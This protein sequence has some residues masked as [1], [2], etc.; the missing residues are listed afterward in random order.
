[1]FF[2]QRNGKPVA[3]QFEVVPIS[4]DF[5]MNIWCGVLQFALISLDQKLPQTFL[6]PEPQF[7]LIAPANGNNISDA[8]CIHD[9]AEADFH[10]FISIFV[11]YRLG[12]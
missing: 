7:G 9:H 2:T 3:T 5:N 12:I 1:L 4:H 8:N 6:Y 11:S 10:P